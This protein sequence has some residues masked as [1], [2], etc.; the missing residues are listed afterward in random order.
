MGDYIH[1]QRARTQSKMDSHE[2][3]NSTQGGQTP[4]QI[5]A[6]LILL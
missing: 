1:E 4:N 3:V 5:R 2:Q 6:F